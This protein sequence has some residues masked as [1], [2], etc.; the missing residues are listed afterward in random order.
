M[1]LLA[2]VDDVVPLHGLDRVR[3]RARDEHAVVVRRRADVRSMD[4][5]RDDADRV[6][7]RVEV[8]HTSVE[9]KILYQ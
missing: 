5:R 1:D 2:E 7:G 9:T 6:G 3:A 4:H 8:D